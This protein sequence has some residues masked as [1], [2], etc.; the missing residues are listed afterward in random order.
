MKKGA[1]ILIVVSAI[2]TIIAIVSRITLTPAGGV[3]PRAMMGFAGLLL[4][5]AIALEGLK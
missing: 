2:V 4:L 1:K 5:F 3:G